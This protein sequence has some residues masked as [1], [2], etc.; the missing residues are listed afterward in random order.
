VESL[1]A[2]RNRIEHFS[3][4]KRE[5]DQAV[6]G[7][8]LKFVTFFI[9]DVLDHRLAEEM[10]PGLLVEMKRVVFSYDELIARANG[11]MEQWLRETFGAWDAE[12]ED[13][14]SGFEGT[15]PCPACGVEYLVV[16]NVD[17]PHCFFCGSDIHAGECEICG[18]TYLISNGPCCDTGDSDEPDDE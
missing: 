4:E 2:R 8:S 17:K 16:D 15:L 13:F 10:N 14:P 3:Y 7:Q 6:I 11:R 1:Q 5:P 9:E 18:R 12:L